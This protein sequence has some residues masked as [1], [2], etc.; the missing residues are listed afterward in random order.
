MADPNVVPIDHR[1]RR[2]SSTSD[3]ADLADL[4]AAELAH[5]RAAG[6]RVADIAHGSDLPRAT[7]E[8]DALG[9]N[10]EG[11]AERIYQRIFREPMAPLRNPR[12]P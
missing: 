6:R 5:V 10:I 12:R 9:V 2:P 1:T 8:L 3:P 11:I 4:I 7:I